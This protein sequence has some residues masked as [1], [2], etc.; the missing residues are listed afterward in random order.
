MTLLGGLREE[1][2]TVITTPD[3]TQATWTKEEV[4][5]RLI[6]EEMRWIN[7][8][9]DSTSSAY[10]LRGAKKSVVYTKP[11]NNRGHAG[12]SASSS[13]GGHT[14]NNNR[15]HARERAC[16]Y[17]KKVGYWWRECR[18]KPRDW[19]PTSPT[20]EERRANVV[21]SG[22]DAKELVFIAGEGALGGLAWLLNTGATQHMTPHT[23]LL[24]DVSADAPIK[25]V[26]F[27]N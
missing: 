12:G 18:S 10:F 16:R 19:T 25:R 2:S 24:E 20:Q 13:R 23:E 22:E 9:G 17:Y 5:M 8:K 6:N 14:N 4:T 26:V 27:G 15:G 1:W 11:R 3:G 21:T 7:L